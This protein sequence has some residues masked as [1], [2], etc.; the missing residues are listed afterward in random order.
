LSISEAL[1]EREVLSFDVP[2]RLQ[3]LPELLGAHV[4]R[5]SKTED[6]DARYAIATTSRLR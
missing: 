3:R 2:E 5:I 6:A 4:L 1:N